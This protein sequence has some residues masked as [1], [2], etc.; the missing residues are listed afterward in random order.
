MIAAPARSRTH[1]H[2]LAESVPAWSVDWR[3][4]CGVPRLS[5]SDIHVF[6][7][8]LDAP[9]SAGSSSLSADELARASRFAS[10]A[11]SRRFVA[12]RTGM[13]SVLA[14]F[15]GVSPAALVFTYSPRGR[16][17]LA[18]T[19]AAP[20][21]F[22]LT[23]SAGVALLAVSRSR[24]G[25]DVESLRR[26]PPDIM[27]IATRYFSPTESTALSHLPPVARWRAFVTAWTRKEAVAKAIDTGVAA[28]REVEVEVAPD[29]PPRVVSA[30]D[31]PARW[32]LFHL[33][34]EDGMLGAVASAGEARRLVTWDWERRRQ[35]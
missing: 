14:L 23:H 34:S 16:P 2:R 27:G 5:S 1:S 10:D 3:T 35:R 22:N 29:R 25:V 33:E 18:A 24:V 26:P 6:R 13:R 9:T 21:D 12:A 17:M 30:P 19:D 20:L 32:R 4:P 31:G 8:E 11:D 28:L 15:T 7:I